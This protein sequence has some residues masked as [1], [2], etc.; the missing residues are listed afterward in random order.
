METVGRILHVSLISTSAG[1]ENLSVC[2]TYC[3][4]TNNKGATLTKIYFHCYHEIVCGHCFNNNCETLN[5]HSFMTMYS[6]FLLFCYSRN[7][8]FSA[9]TVLIFFIVSSQCHICRSRQPGLLLP[10][11]KT[12]LSVGLLLLQYLG[13]C[14]RM[15]MSVVYLRVI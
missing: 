13:A 7:I 6:L 5:I 3:Q 15:E 11:A 2:I 12:S 10:Q 9:G 14:G 1:I 8:S 4:H